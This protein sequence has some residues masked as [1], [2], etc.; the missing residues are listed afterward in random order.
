MTFHELLKTLQQDYLQ[1]I[2]EKVKVIQG[3]IQT[4]DTH[5]VRESFHKLKG[6]GRTY[7][8]PEVSELGELVENVCLQQPQAGVQAAEQAVPVLMEIY[9]SRKEQ[10]PYEFEADS[11]VAALR[12][13]LQTG[14]LKD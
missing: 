7:G 10:T 4:S 8:L 13:L 11:R 2:P 3:H 5:N 1:S 6:T 9:R 14:S 12:K